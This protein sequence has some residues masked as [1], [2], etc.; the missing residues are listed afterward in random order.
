M[1]FFPPVF[2]SCFSLQGML[3]CMQGKG[4]PVPNT[5]PYSI[6]VILLKPSVY[7]DSIPP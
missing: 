1:L 3:C 5:L 4:L 2:A 6:S 7:Q